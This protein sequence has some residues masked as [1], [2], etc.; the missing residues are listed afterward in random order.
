MSSEAQQR[1]DAY[2]YPGTETFRNKLGITDPSVLREVEYA[3]TALRTAQLVRGQVEVPRTW[4]AEHV[5]GIHGH[6][7]QDV[8]EWAGQYRTVGMAKGEQ[9]FAPVSPEGE[10]S[11]IEA[12][13][14]RVQQEAV[15][16]DWERAS[17]EEIAHGLVEVQGWL[18]FAHPAREG[19]GRT[20][21][22]FL[23]QL[24]EQTGRYT[25]EATALDR[26]KWAFM[27]RDAMP[28]LERMSV[29]HELADQG[30]L[31]ALKPVARP[32]RH[33]VWSAERLGAALAGGQH[34]GASE[35]AA[36]SHRGATGERHQRSGYER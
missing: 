32:A 27:A 11:V 22:E 6:L 30:M 28:T 16:V 19:N 5:M 36:M 4:G 25:F 1:W 34:T 35:G 29:N 13:L 3:A 10:P 14:E 2:F 8:Y 24:T 17:E 26:A 33:Q 18:N 15:R 7:F 20:Q 9:G 31:E 21:F 12:V 23:R